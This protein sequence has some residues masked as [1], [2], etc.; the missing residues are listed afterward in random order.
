M[1][2]KVGELV[3]WISVVAILTTA[4][5][6]GGDGGPWLAAIVGAVL[7]A[8]VVVV[9][10]RAVS[11][12]TRLQNYL[13][14]GNPDPM[15]RIIRRR[16]RYRGGGRHRLPLVI[17]QGAAYSMKGEFAEGL[18]AL[19]AL[20]LETELEAVEGDRQR[21]IW[22]LAYHSTRLSCLIFLERIDEAREL[23]D[24]E[25]AGRRDSPEAE[26]AVRAVEAE[27]WFCEDR[28]R[29]AEKV[30]SEIV[31]DHRLPP[32]SRAVFHYFLGRI[33]RDSGDR[34][35]SEEQF[36]RARDLGGKTWIADGI[37]ALEREEARTLAAFK[38]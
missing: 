29:D 7:V 31:G 13:I 25:L 37:A 28:R 21:K 11:A 1:S 14:E 35:A 20:D 18:E 15:L 2:R 9:F 32:S 30:F 16:L 33:Y 8:T 23:F 10:L 12:L 24:R 22:E 5:R 6:L 17:Y 3:V 19:D 4:F 26:L 38:R 27:L 36:D 34:D